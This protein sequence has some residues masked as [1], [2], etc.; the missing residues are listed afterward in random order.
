MT[1]GFR[2]FV[3]DFFILCIVRICPSSIIPSSNECQHSHSLFSTRKLQAQS[4][5]FWRSCASPADT[6]FGCSLVISFFLPSSLRTVPRLFAPGRFQLFLR[7]SKDSSLQPQPELLASASL[8]SHTISKSSLSTKML[9][10]YLIWV[11]I[12]RMWIS[13]FHRISRPLIDFYHD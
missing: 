5:R 2:W 7:F 8:C 1:S 4:D 9:V 10:I 13:P 11:Y 3:R 12:L 6:L